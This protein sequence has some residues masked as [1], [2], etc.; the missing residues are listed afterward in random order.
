MN[1]HPHPAIDSH[2]KNTQGEQFFVIGSGTGGII[3]QYYDGRVEMINRDTW[4]QLKL[5]P[6][7]PL[8]I[9]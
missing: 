7:E 9:N 8:C 6:C 4:T 5:E 2:Y 1:T 3:V